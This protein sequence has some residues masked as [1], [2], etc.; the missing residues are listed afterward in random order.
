[1]ARLIEVDGKRPSIG[2]GCFLAPTAVLV[3][4]VRLGDGVNVWFGAVLR[5]DLSWVEVGAGSSIQDNVVIHCA[6]DLPTVIHPE[7]LV[8]H[9][10]MLE[11]CEVDEHA[12]IGM[13]A[14]VL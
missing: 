8:G 13:G 3:G 1:M 5:G 7:V 12:V 6:D 2:D 14:I 10:A 11:G 9:G 4:D